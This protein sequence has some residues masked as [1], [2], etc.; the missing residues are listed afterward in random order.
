MRLFDRRRPDLPSLVKHAVPL[1]PRERVL[2]WA[3]DEVTGGHLVA[4]THHL[5]FV[6]PS[7]ELSWQRPW[8]EAESGTWQSGSSMLTVVWVD[9][10]QRD[11][12]RISE[13]SL[14]QQTLR[15]RLQA[16]VVLSDE[17]RTEARRTVRVVIRQDLAT[18]ALIEQVIPNRGA[19]LSD[20]AV[21]AE[22]A[23]RLSRLRAEVG[24]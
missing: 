8:H 6:D 22:V 2:A 16:S 1:S 19:D 13:P 7:G 11:R 21:A 3:L 14:L 17:F 12:W 10:Q 20:P 5:A 4:S 9:H 23:S 18:G 24:L 15:E